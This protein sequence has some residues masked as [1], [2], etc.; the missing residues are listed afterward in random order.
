MSLSDM[1]SENNADVNMS[2]PLGSVMI[3]AFRVG[4][5]L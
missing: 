3:S 2:E 1:E 5:N 4:L